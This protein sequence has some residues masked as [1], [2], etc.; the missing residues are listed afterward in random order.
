MADNI[1]INVT[2]II[3]EVTIEVS[4]ATQGKDGV[5]LPVG[6]SIGQVPIKQSATDYDIAWETPSGLGDMTKSVYDTNNSGVVDDAEKV[7]GLTVA[8]SVPSGALFTDT[9]YDDTT[10]QGEVDLNTA[11]VGLTSD[12][13]GITELKQEIL[14]LF[15]ITR[16][17]MGTTNII[18]WSG[19]NGTFLR[20]TL[21]SNIT[22]S[23]TNLPQ[24][25]DTKPITLYVN[26]S[27]FSITPP[28]YWEFMGG[29][30]K[31]S[32]INEFTIEC[33]NGNSGSELVYYW[34]NPKTV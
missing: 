17:D 28:A 10:I 34:I 24:G 12:S 7:N 9:V 5:G 13:V 22:L 27:T 8:K 1:D 6:G 23:D 19:T 3:R 21:T 2:P 18:D 33:V 14:D 30:P 16:V 31:P 15:N 25:T 4:Q 32:V 20:D 29:M 26:P 11:K